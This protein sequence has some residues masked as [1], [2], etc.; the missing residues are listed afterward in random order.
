MTQKVPNIQLRAWRDASHLTRVE[1]AEALNQ[2]GT[3]REARLNCDEKRLARWETGEVLWSHAIY[4]QAL[5]ELTGR[6]AEDLGFVP[7]HRRAERSR[8][9]GLLCP[10]TPCRPKPRSSTRWS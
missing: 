6:D 2:T 3:G 5:H 8:W 7:Q 1:M 4:R 9:S 10:A